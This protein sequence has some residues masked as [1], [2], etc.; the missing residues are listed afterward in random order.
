MEIVNEENPNPRDAIP[1]AA[2]DAAVAWAC[3]EV[4]VRESPES[5]RLK[6]GLGPPD[7]MLRL[8]WG[9]GGSWVTRGAF[10]RCKKSPRWKDI[11]PPTSLEVWLASLQPMEEILTQV[12]QRQAGGE[13]APGLRTAAGTALQGGLPRLLGTV[14]SFRSYGSVAQWQLHASGVF[15][16]AWSCVAVP[17]PCP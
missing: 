9:S 12:D 13:L 14:P 8:I 3:T 16:Q 17:S 5:W 2:V 11:F 6:G 15:L 4:A 7:A 10:S 1:K